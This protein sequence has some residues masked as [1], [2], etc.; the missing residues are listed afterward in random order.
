MKQSVNSEDRDLLVLYGI[1]DHKDGCKYGFLFQKVFKETAR[2]CD[3]YEVVAKPV[4]ERVFNGYNG[5]ILAYGQTGTGKTHSITGGSDNSSKGM[6][7][8]AFN[9][10]FKL[11][12]NAPEKEYSVSIS[13][14]EIYNELCY[15][16]LSEEGS[17]HEGFT[18]VLLL[19]D[20]AGTV[21]LRNLSEHKVFEMKE[22]DRL[23]KKGMTN[24]TVADTPMN[25]VSSRSHCIFTLHLRQRVKPGDRKCVKSKL[26]MIDLSG[27][28]RVWKN[29]TSGLLLH[30]AK[31]INLSL[32]YLEQVIIALSE[33]QRLHVPYRNSTITSL[34]RDS[35]GGNSHTAMVFTLSLEPNNFHVQKETLSTCRFSQRV[36]LVK[37]HSQKVIDYSSDTEEELVFLRSEVDRL[38]KIIGKMKIG[39]ALN[40]DEENP[41]KNKAEA[42]DNYEEDSF[43]EYD[44][45]A[46]CS[47][48]QEFC[49]IACNIESIQMENVT[50]PNVPLE[51][52]VLSKST[53]R[54]VELPK[55]S[56][57]DALKSIP[58]EDVLKNIPLEPNESEAMS[59][60]SSENNKKVAVESPAPKHI[61]PFRQNHCVGL[62]GENEI[63]LSFDFKSTVSHIN[64]GI[65]MLTTL[66]RHVSSVLTIQEEERIKMFD[67]EK[68]SN[69]M[70]LTLPHINPNTG[71]PYTDEKREAFTTF[72]HLKKSNRALYLY[73][74]MHISYFSQLEAEWQLWKKVSSLMPELDLLEKELQNAQSKGEFPDVLETLE[75]AYIHKKRKLERAKEKLEL[76][77]KERFDS[78]RMFRDAKQSLLKSFEL[79]WDEKGCQLPIETVQTKK[80][81]SLMRLRKW[82]ENLRMPSS[83]KHGTENRKSTDNI[84]IL[85]SV[86]EEQPNWSMR[87]NEKPL[88]IKGNSDDIKTNI[89]LG[90]IRET[91]SSQN[92]FSLNKISKDISDGQVLNRRTVSAHV[93][94][95]DS[96]KAEVSVSR[97]ENA[98]AKEEPSQPE[99]HS[100]QLW[101]NEVREILKNSDEKLPYSHHSGGKLSQRSSPNSSATMIHELS[102]QKASLPNIRS[103]DIKL[104]GDSDID[105][106]IMNFYNNRAGT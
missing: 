72:L 64:R 75:I 29:N 12:K 18:K 70:G 98:S 82:S 100:A 51:D 15:D 101:Q 3:L 69:I 46:S 24:R 80:T 74:E 32:H 8:R 23:L 97:G 44:E 54:D 65:L 49:K 66:L 41:T 94:N 52:E 55:I 83:T 39:V 40:E 104:T 86:S 87:K 19:E 27:S 38:R 28:E 13:T 33:R 99:E 77:S 5:A 48:D 11:I 25:P 92:C 2:Q 93:M 35:L 90:F 45:K 31:H 84:N 21:K 43:E 88:M 89:H 1:P 79:W 56:L 91:S 60:L 7:P 17:N 96:G 6:I 95:F 85:K 76:L 57:E 53:I 81:K 58:L 68:L 105:K 9:G 47:S 36:S 103:I 26:H 10:M 34:L 78:L 67:V 71:E 30:E 73:A 59:V 14:M 22:V 106:E 50:M 62:Q 63:S 4:V 37:T 102:K 42:E 20:A 61:E 16:L